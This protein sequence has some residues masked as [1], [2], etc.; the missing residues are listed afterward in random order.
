MKKRFILLALAAMTITG[1]GA[2]AQE[3]SPPW[4]IVIH[5]GAGVIERAKLSPELATAY[6]RALDT[7]LAAGAKILAEG[8]SGLDAVETAIR[9]MEDDPL[10]NAGRGAVF[11]AE[12]RNELDASVMEGTGLKAG[13]V[14]G[15]RTTRHPI[16][17]ARA[18]MEKSPH[19]LLAGGD[20]DR[21]AAANGLEQVKPGFFFTER[22]WQGLVNFLAA[23]GET[24][25]K[26][27]RGVPKPPRDTTREAV[28]A[29]AID[30]ATHG[31]GT[32]GVAVMD[33]SGHWAAG[34]STGG[35]TG[36]RWGR[37]GDAPII[38]AGTYAQDGI[39]A[40]SA[41]GT[42]EYFIRLGVARRICALVELRG[43]SIQAAV[44]Q[45]IETELSALGGDGGVI[46]IGPRGE[47]AFGLNT[48][49]MYRARLTSAGDKEISIFA[50]E[51]G[52]R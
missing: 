45:V 17:A 42:G 19:V 41:T 11:S 16:S 24:P 43:M 40:V 6:R 36:K 21:F 50:D 51:G 49:G 20:A 52:D 30:T 12:G 48:S 29:A 39:C 47:T 4:S 1:A 9:I 27:P 44:R 46:A 10:F 25:P 37:V 13:A 26:R 33:Q 3:K 34:T 2:A 5:G 7:A 22:R 28:K 23:R 38:G 35:T 31:F 15:L 32:V 8:G 18:V 14:A